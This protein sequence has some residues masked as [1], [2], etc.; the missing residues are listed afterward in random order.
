MDPV[1]RRIIAAAACAPSAENSQPWRFRVEDGRITLHDTG[2]TSLYAFETKGVPISYGALLE[3]IAIAA[4]AEGF[5]AIIDI[6][7][8]GPQQPIASIRLEKGVRDPGV[9]AVIS[10]RVTNRKPYRR[11]ALS[12]KAIS[13][14]EH[15]AG[16]A[17]AVGITVTRV[18]SR[19]VIDR[20]ALVAGTNER[21]MLGN[22][23]MHHDFFSNLSWTPEQNMKRKSGFFIRTLELPVPVQFIFRILRFW[24]VASLL[25]TIGF[26]A[27]VGKANA[28]TY[29]NCAEFGVISMKSDRLQDFINAGRA[30]ERIWLTATA[31]GVSLQPL[32]GTPLMH[33]FVQKGGKGH[34]DARERDLLSSAVAEIRAQ[35]H[36][37]D[38]YIVLM[39]RLG[40]G[41]EPSARADR[42]SVEEL[43]I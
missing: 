14:L 16:A 21:I 43:L 41:D 33:Y 31:C 29:A 15:E 22:M 2:G 23:E 36:I 32:G 5:T 7:Q 18:V 42:F 30:F 9:A 1:I 17:R 13:A 6:L 37:Q 3:N 28:A 40:Y 38:P 10:R 27:F 24:S 19:S 12:A 25:K 11:D 8:R 35:T 26:P 39:Y 4:K 34:F 20:L